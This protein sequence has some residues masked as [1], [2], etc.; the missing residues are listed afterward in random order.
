MDEK[1]NDS[2][3]LLQSE[4]IIITFG[5]E[6]SKRDARSYIVCLAGSLDRRD[7]KPSSLVPRI[8]IFLRIVVA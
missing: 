7:S 6:T 1:S 8:V 2:N 3:S 4:N 5:R